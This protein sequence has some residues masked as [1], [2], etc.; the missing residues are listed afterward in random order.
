MNVLIAGGAGYIG[1]TVA[2]E[3]L[4]DGHAVTVYDSLIH[5]HLAA[6][7]EGARFVQGDILEDPTLD[8]VL[9]E[10]EF[11]AAMHFAAFIEAGASMREPGR[12][13]RNNVSGSIHL[14][15][16]AVAHGIS[17]LVFSSSAGVYAT[18]DTPL[19]EDDPVGPASVYGQTKRMIEEILAW[20]HEVRGLRYVALRYFNAAGGTPARGEDHHP[21]THLIPNILRVPLGQQEQF[22]LFGDDYPTRD[23]T[24][25]RDYVHILDLASAHLLALEALDERGAM[26]YNVGNGAGYTNLEVLEAAR[27]VTG[28][29]IP[30]TISPRRPGDAP[31]LVADAARIRAE[32]GWQPQRL[33]LEEIVASA[34]AWHRAHPQGYGDA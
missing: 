18:K 4:K 15:D 22:T 2:A 31:A 27:R 14:I 9:A 24:C 10:G 32:L 12:F 16:T 21:E 29:P 13:F 20:Y 26:I 5:G 28:H 19:V 25:V 7:P 1:S 30:T 8:R 11:D 34:W 17:R 33:D 23:G 3:L 6:I